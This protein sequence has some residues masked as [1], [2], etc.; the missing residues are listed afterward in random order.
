MTHDQH[1]KTSTQ[2]ALC[3]I[4]SCRYGICVVFRNYTVQFFCNVNK[5]RTCQVAN[6]AQLV[7]LAG[8]PEDLDSESRSNFSRVI[9]EIAH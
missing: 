4:Q 1:K 7:T 8:A 5:H 6:R 3:Y 2:L 9:E